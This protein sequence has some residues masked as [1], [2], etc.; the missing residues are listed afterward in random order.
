MEGFVDEAET[1]H[2]QRLEALERVFR[3]AA[4][5][6]MPAEVSAKLVSDIAFIKT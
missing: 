5:A 3:E 2:S 4:E 1:S 6:D